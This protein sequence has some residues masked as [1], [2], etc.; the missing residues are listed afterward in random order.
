MSDVANGTASGQPENV[1]DA[2]VGA[3]ALSRIRAIQSA[4]GSESAA[5]QSMQVSRRPC[6]GLAAMTQSS[7]A[8]PRSENT[9]L[10]LLRHACVY[11][12]GGGA[13]SLLATFTC[14]PCLI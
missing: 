11:G 3:S 12:G 14:L 8:W 13:A 1:S 6:R 4:A 10:F 5:D 9:F 2:S 7:A